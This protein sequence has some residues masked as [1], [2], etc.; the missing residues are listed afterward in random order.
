MIEKMV[1]EIT[2][3]PCHMAVCAWIMKGVY[4]VVRKRVFMDN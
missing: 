2:K 1:C 4:K 3:I